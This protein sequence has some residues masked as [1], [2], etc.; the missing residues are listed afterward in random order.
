MKFKNEINL[1]LVSSEGEK[2]IFEADEIQTLPVFEEIT[3]FNP[4]NRI[5]LFVLPIE[6]GHFQLKIEINLER[7]LSC[8]RCGEDYQKLESHSVEDFLS[9][10]KN[11]EGEDQGFV[12]LDSPNWDWSSFVVETLELETPYLNYKYGEK[13]LKSCPHYDE[14]VQ[15]GWITEGSGKESP[16]KVLEKLKN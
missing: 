13:C 2:F 15:K 16:F 10:N 14:A 4:Q 9:L 1:N 12:V 8:S 7:P 5:E 3:I 11:D 6:G